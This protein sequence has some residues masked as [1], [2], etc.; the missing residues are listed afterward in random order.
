MHGVT[1]FMEERQDCDLIFPASP[2]GCKSGGPSEISGDADVTE[3]VGRRVT[4]LVLLTTVL[5]LK[6]HGAAGP[7]EI[8]ES[9]IWESNAALHFLHSLQCWCFRKVFTGKE[10]CC[11]VGM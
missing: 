11:L 5:L 7:A 1:A 3:F 8:T 4:L 2:L 9:V 6:E 10:R